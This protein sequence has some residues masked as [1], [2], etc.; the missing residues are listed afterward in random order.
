MKKLNF[1]WKETRLLYQ[2]GE[3][4]YLG[5]IL[6]ASY[7]WNSN[8]SKEDKTNDNDWVGEVNLPSLTFEAKR[9]YGTTPEEIKA[10]IEK[11]VTDWFNEA[12]YNSSQSSK[13]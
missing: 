9:Q 4:L 13:V 2:S 11:T 1:Q 6:L 5:R 3:S 10:R 8:R 7:S 12:Y